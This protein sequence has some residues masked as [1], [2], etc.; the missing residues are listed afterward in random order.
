MLHALAVSVAAGILSLGGPS[1][2][3]ASVTCPPEGAV[4]Q[5]VRGVPGDHYYWFTIEP[6]P[7]TA[8][9]TFTVNGSLTPG[10]LTTTVAGTTLEGDF[11][12]ALVLV[13]GDRV[14]MRAGSLSGEYCATTP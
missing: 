5:E 11:R 10:S 2:A 4:C 8:A 7:T 9:F 12:P 3:Q 6:A 13:R 1:P 14:C